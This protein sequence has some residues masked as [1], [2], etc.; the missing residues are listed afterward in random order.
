MSRIAVCLALLAAYCAAV[1]W[2]LYWVADHVDFS[3]FMI[4]GILTIATMVSCGFAYDHF[5]A[6]SRR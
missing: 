2:A 6:R 4:L 1:R 5:Q 3:S